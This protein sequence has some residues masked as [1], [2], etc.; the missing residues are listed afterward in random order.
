MAGATYNSYTIIID[1]CLFVKLILQLGVLD[2]GPGISIS[3]HR[4]LGRRQDLLDTTRVQGSL[5]NSCGDH[6]GRVEISER[7]G[8]EVGST[9]GEDLGARAL[10]VGIWIGARGSLDF[11]GRRSL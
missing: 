3:P 4:S 7:R 2:D 6:G 5:V 10:L 11:V 1:M 8:M 9:L